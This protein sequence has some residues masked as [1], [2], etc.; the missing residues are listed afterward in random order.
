MFNALD[1][2]QFLQILDLSD[3][4]GLRAPLFDPAADATDSGICLLATR[5]SVLNMA[6]IGAFALPCLWTSA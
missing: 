3:A 1:T 2:L 5:L 6:E 4:S